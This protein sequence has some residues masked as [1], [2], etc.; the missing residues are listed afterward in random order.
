VV[1]ATGP[2]SD[3]VAA[4]LAGAE[5]PRRLRASRGSHLV[6]PRGALAEG[7]LLTAR[8]DG[9]VF[10]VVP[11]GDH[12]LLGT[13]EVEDS[14]GPGADLPA[15]EEVRYLLDECGRAL[16]GAG[17][18]AAR[19]VGLLTGVRPLVAGRG[20][21]G[22][23]SREHHVFVEGRVVTVVGG[24]YTTFRPMSRDVMRRVLP[25]LGRRAREARLDQEPLPGC[26]PG[27]FKQY[28]KSE[29]QHL[30][31]AFPLAAEHVPRL[32]RAHGCEA[33]QV[34]AREPREAR[35]LATGVPALAAEV[36]YAVEAE[37]AR[38]LDDVMRRR[39]ALWLSP[40]FGRRAARPVAR[41]MAELL[42]WSGE[43]EAEE[44]ERWNRLA[45]GEERLLRAA[46]ACSGE[47][48]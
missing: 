26:P 19:A 5:R 8:R 7:L 3:Q 13:T 24:K 16:P 27:D 46:G 36:R 12:V 42:G 48:R 40:D 38:R 28:M 23:A 15:E 32:L 33:R 35:P 31:A 30:A 21:L 1:N 17:F 11:A 18:E 10:F 6:F 41:R 44:L 20:S 45:A 22:R 37:H 47:G 14:H 2:W 39:T 29:A 43:R 4:R 25:L 34:L 9:R